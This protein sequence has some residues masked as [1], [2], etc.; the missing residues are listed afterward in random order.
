MIIKMQ[1]MSSDNT[2]TRADVND[3]TED[4]GSVSCRKS[5]KMALE[6]TINLSPAG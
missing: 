6:T 1:Y 4:T 2:C 3:K 5:H